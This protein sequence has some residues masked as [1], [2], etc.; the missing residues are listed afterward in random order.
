[1]RDVQYLW[2]RN[3]DMK[4][5]DVIPFDLDKL[6]NILWEKGIMS[7]RNK[8]RNN[9]QVSNNFNQDWLKPPERDTFG[10]TP[11]EAFRIK[12]Y[13]GETDT[14]LIFYGCK[15]QYLYWEQLCS[16]DLVINF[17]GTKIPV[18]MF[19]S[20]E[21]PSSSNNILVNRVKS[22]ERQHTELILNCPDGM[23]LPD[24]YNLS[25]W[26]DIYEWAIQN[27]MKRIICCCIGAFGR[28]GTGLASLA[29]A[30]HWDFFSKEDKRSNADVLIINYI[31]EHY[32]KKAIETSLQEKYI[33]SLVE[34]GM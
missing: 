15:H 26:R 17:T 31:R 4:L 9:K 19:K 7:N 5:G 28:T 8:N 13:E 24:N 18:N 22:Y 23:F 3:N 33:K 20:L 16:T 32:C 21:G 12:A 30:T 10:F 27:N 2:F 29:L 14:D 11:V 1:M 34:Q 25:F 6:R